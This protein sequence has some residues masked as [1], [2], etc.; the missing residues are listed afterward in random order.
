MKKATT[1]DSYLASLAPEVKATLAQVRAAIRAAAPQAEEGISYGMPVYKRNGMLVG[2]AA[3]K[4]HWSL[5]PMNGTY[6]AAHAAELKGYT[7]TKG[8]IHV[9]Y[10]KSPPLALVRKLVKERLAENEAKL[11]E[12]KR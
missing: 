6:V 7:T 3:F 5:M 4:D 8:T 2:F 11:K 1:V 12:K 9:P 10:G